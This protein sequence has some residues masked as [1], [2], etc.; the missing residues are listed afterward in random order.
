MKETIELCEIEAD[1]GGEKFCATFSESLID[2]SISRLGKRV[3]VLSDEVKKETETGD[4]TIGK[5]VK[6]VGQKEIVC[7]KMSYTYAV[8]L[9]HSIGKIDVYTVPLVGSDG[10]KVKATTLCHK[11]TSIWN[12]EDLAFKVL[13]VKPG[14]IP[15]CHFLNKETVVW[16]PN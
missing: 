11:D 4:F 13:K 16:I 9:C 5:E 14:S 7:H 10:T 12:P 15:I 1:K 3:Q 2:Q 6:N 8:F